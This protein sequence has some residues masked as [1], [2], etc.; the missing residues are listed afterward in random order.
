MTEIIT[1]QN[2]APP[3]W[4]PEPEQEGPV[5]AQVWMMNFTCYDPVS[6]R[7]KYSGNCTNMEFEIHK[8][9]SSVIEGEFFYETHY[10]KNGVALARPV[11]E[12]TV[13]GEAVADGMTEMTMHG[14]PEGAILKCSGAESFSAEV[15]YE[16]EDF[17]TLVFASPGEHI[18]DVDA[19]PYLTERIIIN[20]S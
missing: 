6:G 13:Q 3:T 12:I 2:E 5:Q 7:V 4:E 8:T 9:I 11:A 16:G 18:F 20:A 19:F 10:V 17:I 14:V 1:T 15:H